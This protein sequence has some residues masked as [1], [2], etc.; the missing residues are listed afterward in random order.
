MRINIPYAGFGL[1]LLVFSHQTAAQELELD[2]FVRSILKNNPGVQK[3]LADKTIAAGALES[4]QGVDDGVLSSSLSLAHSEPNQVL[5]FEPSDSDDVR[6]N[7]A[8]DRQFSTSG[9]RLNLSYGNQYTDRNPP[10]GTLGEQYYQPSFTV[11]LTQP[12]LKNAG[13]IQDSLDINLKRLNLKLAEL[14]SQ[15]NLESYITQLARLYLDWY[16]AARETAISKEV[17]QQSIEQEK[18]TRIKVKRQVIEPYE[19]LRAQETREDYYSRWLQSQGRYLG[20]SHQIQRQMNSKQYNAADELTPLDPQSSLLFTSS[21]STSSSAGY[22]ASTSRL[23][24]ILDTLQDQQQLLLDAKYDAKQSDLNLSLGYTR[25]GVDSD[26][27]DAHTSNL[28]QDDYSVMLEYRYPL[29]N[30]RAS[31]DYQTQLASKHQLEADTQQRMIDAESSLANLQEQEAQ[32]VTALKSIDRKIAL[33][34]K[35]LTKEQRLYKIGKLDLFELLKDQTAHLES[36]LQ[37]EQLLTRLLALRLS[38]GELLDQNLTVF[39]EKTNVAPENK[40]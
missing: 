38:I 31:G 8:Y 3:I 19:L 7:L 26:F 2:T 20:L 40:T 28:K 27:N 36:R 24:N 11:R 1:A 29:G 10:L 30:K 21:Q 34:T 37:K 22:L 9:T 33:A 6:L 4:S 35:K 18:L 39:T 23:K 25:H 5:G 17:H 16:L 15:E 13:G 14:S 32:L 12:L